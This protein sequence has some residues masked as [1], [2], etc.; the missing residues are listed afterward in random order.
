MSSLTTFQVTTMS[1]KVQFDNNSVVEDT[2]SNAS[3]ASEA[4]EVYLWM[5]IMKDAAYTFKKSLSSSDEEL[6]AYIDFLKNIEIEGKALGAIQA[7]ATDF[8]TDDYLKASGL[9]TAI[10]LESA[11]DTEQVVMKKIVGDIT[12]SNRML[13]NESDFQ[14]PTTPN[15]EEMPLLVCS[16]ERSRGLHTFEEAKE[17]WEKFLGHL[18]VDTSMSDPTVTSEKNNDSDSDEHSVNDPTSIDGIGSKTIEKLQSG[19]FDVSPNEERA[20]FAEPFDFESDDDSDENDDEST[21]GGMPSPDK[22][23]ELQE[24]GWTKEEIKDLYGK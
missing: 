20:E 8:T 5:R 11:N 15:K 19:G 13:L 14:V 12:E 24:N 17:M 23:I 3:E 21:T 22:I 18:S 10:S 4:T 16:N 7:K 6:E 9:G 2:F 1:A